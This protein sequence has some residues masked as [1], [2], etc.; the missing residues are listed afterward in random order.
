[1]ISSFLTL[2]KK[3]ESPAPASSSSC[4]VKLMTYYSNSI[5]CAHISASKEYGKLM[6]LWYGL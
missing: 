2:A 5:F 6:A 3:A 4:S 1:M